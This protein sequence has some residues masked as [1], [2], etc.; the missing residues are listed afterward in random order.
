MD[1]MDISYIDVNE[2]G[3]RPLNWTDEENDI[4]F[5]DI[6]NGYFRKEKLNELQILNNGATNEEDT[7]MSDDDDSNYEIDPETGKYKIFSLNLLN[8]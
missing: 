1:L 8:E 4:D 7:S 5:D 2:L 3:V 6:S